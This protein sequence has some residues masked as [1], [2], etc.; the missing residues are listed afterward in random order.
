MDSFQRDYQNRWILL[1]RKII[2]GISEEQVI[3]I[4]ELESEKLNRAQNNI[5]EYQILYRKYLTVRNNL[6]DYDRIVELYKEKL[7][8][9]RLRTQWKFRRKHISKS[10]E[11][12]RIL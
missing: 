9:L 6:A 3:E 5:F 4:S 1:N 2:D 7:K 8:K 12:L 10:I 11:F